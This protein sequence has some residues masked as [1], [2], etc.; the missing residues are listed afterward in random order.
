[1]GDSDRA[2]P[3]STTIEAGP[4][5]QTIGD[6]QSAAAAG[7]EGV[8]A[9]AVQPVVI[10]AAVK[11][12]AN[13]TSLSAQ[14][15]RIGR[16]LVLRMLGEGGMGVVYAGYDEE[17]DRKVAIKL[18]H[19]AQQGDSQLRARILREAQSLARVSAPNVVHVYEVGEFASQLYI[20][21][22][23]VNG[24]TLSK[25]QSETTRTWKEILRMYLAAG[26]GLLEAHVAGLVHRDFK[27]DNV[28]LGQD[29][30]PRV[31]DFGLAR[32]QTKAG[33]LGKSPVSAPY[34]SVSGQ[35]HK[36]PAQDPLTPLTQAGVVMGTPIYMSPE[37]HLG[38]ATDSRSDQFSFCVAL[39]EA[40]YH[41]L[42]FAGTTA[43]AL[44]VSALKGRIQ[45]RPASSRVPIPVHDALVRGL[46]K[47]PELR[48]PSMRELLAALSFD[49]DRDRV[50]A[51]KIRRWV[52][53]SVAA[54]VVLSMGGQ[55][56]L[57]LLGVSEM[58]SSVAMAMALFLFQVLVMVRFRH[59]LKNN[60]FHR[61]VMATGAVFGGQLLVLRVVGILLGLTLTQIM[62]LDLVAVLAMTSMM[63]PLFLP[64]LWPQIPVA[65]LAVAV[66][67]VHPAY[68]QPIAAVVVPTSM[69][70]AIL[71]WSLAVRSR[72]K[73]RRD[74]P[75]NPS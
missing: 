9:L 26:Q 37:Q 70:V 43:Q 11:T 73:T 51:P 10:S 13:G 65:A 29:G 56:V 4:L 34:Q 61:G 28:L 38:E 42:P 44:A 15:P 54:S 6:A 32:M 22:E 8:P 35:V 53:Y 41:Q 58:T 40:L 24:T 39:Y 25:W 72:V 19:P 7:P 33:G 36:N 1:M 69:V 45:P 21:M 16:Y 55:K 50:T 46:A 74:T 18:L 2:G 12:T 71:V 66:A 64:K 59:G 17:L 68:A 67:A 47:T 49:P 27:P 63:A 3:L 75:V 52:A 48:F 20:I 30:R 23:F 57:R 31:A 14:L 60:P 5:A 62:T